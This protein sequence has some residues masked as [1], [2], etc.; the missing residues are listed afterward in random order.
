MPIEML[1]KKT[2]ES[3]PQADVSVVRHAYE[4]ALRAHRSQTRKSGEPYIA[5]PLAVA[6]LLADLRMEPETIVAALLH[7]VLEDNLA[8]NLPQVETEFGK[9]VATLVN[10]V[11]KLTLIDRSFE[12][13]EAESMR[14][15]FIAMS[16]DPRVILIKLADRLHNMRTL[17]PLSAESQRRNARETMDIYAP[18]ASRLGIY[19]LKSELEDLAF[20]YLE[21]ERYQEIAAHLSAQEEERSIYLARVISILGDRLQ[22]AEIAASITGREK[23]IYS[24]HKKMTQKSRDFDQIYDLRAIRVVVSTVPECYSTLGIVHM[25]WRPIPQEFDDYIA[26]PKENGYQSL[27]TAVIGPQGKPFEVQI[28][29]Q[30]MHRFAEYGIAAHWRYKEGGLRRDAVLENRV[31]WLRQMLDARQDSIDAREFVSSLKSDLLPERVLVFT[32]KGDIIELPAGATP[33][34]FAF[35]V[36]TVVG[37]R[38][39]GAKVNGRQVPLDYK[40]QNGDRVEIVTTN[41]GGPSLDWLNESLGYVA[42]HRARQKIR[43]YFRKQNRAEAITIGRDLLEKAIRKLGAQSASFEQLAQMTR[44]ASPEDLFA[45]IGY[46]EVNAQNIVTRL[47]DTQ[48]DEEV[49][50]SKPPAPTADGVVVSEVGGLLTNLARCCNPIPGDPIIGYVTRGRGVTVHRQGCHNMS[51]WAVAERLIPVTWGTAS[52]ERTVPVPIRVVALDRPGL[53]RDVA[54]VVASEGVNMSAA[55]AAT[56]AKDHTAL[57]T[58]TLQVANMEQLSKI[59]TKIERLP[60]VIE[61]FRPSGH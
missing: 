56:N 32:P 61:A 23:H 46:G 53:M 26:N 41:A 15:M 6:D 20:Q 44:F 43:Q 19:R 9:D 42:T 27:H 22:E 13:T 59:I 48:K 12:Q 39:R 30:E 25:L 35:A 8:V 4:F 1:V 14:K 52:V 60:N 3:F 34:D 50:F 38:C 47:L 2:Q 57:L 24:I 16:Q 55:T 17:T 36:H 54:D 5:H 28:R 40:L 58:A 33:I 49:R 29:S 21:P 51:H 11:T 31:A 45:A 37:E 18:L 7:D 10:G